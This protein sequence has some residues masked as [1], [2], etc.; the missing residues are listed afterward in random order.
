[1]IH[2]HFRM[3]APL[4]MRIPRG[5]SFNDIGLVPRETVEVSSRSIA[6]RRCC[7]VRDIYYL[8]VPL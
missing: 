3:P 2:Y 8:M 6:I 5:H 1:M 4:F 7:I